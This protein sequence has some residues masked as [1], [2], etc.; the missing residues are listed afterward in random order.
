MKMESHDRFEIGMLK[1]GNKNKI[2][3][4]SGVLVGHKTIRTG[5]SAR[6]GVTALVPR[7]GNIFGEK[8]MAAC[9]V[10]NGFGK[11]A[12]LIQIEE[13]GT[14]ETP[15]VLTN[16]L[17]VGVAVDALVGYMLDKNDDIGRTA[18]TVN[19]VVCECND[20]YLNDI[21]GRH[22]KSEDVVEAIENASETFEEGDVG[23]GTGMSCY[24]LKGGIGSASRIVETGKCDFTVGVLVLSNFG[25]LTDLTIDG[26]KA[27]EKIAESL[28]TEELREQGSIIVIVATDIPMTERQLKRM[29]KRTAVGI[30]RTGSYEANGSGEVAIAFTTANRISHYEERPTVPI[31]MFNDN[32]VNPAFRAVVEATE[33]AV[34]NS[35]LNAKTTR[36]R[37][38]HTRVSLTEYKELFARD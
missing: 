7:E 19:P 32:M 22:V 38:G 26:I 10:I 18:G 2:T 21:R 13:L 14:I 15:I 23:A 31:E 1:K 25:E 6:T 5:N 28:K 4:V 20:G 24:Q 11:S 33:E 17:S 29:C 30:S 3:D 16:T 34:L 27:G 35:M 12:G 37:E 36:G 8:V 9:H